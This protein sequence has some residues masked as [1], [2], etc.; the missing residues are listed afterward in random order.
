[1]AGLLPW[2][3]LVLLDVKHMDDSAHRAAT[4]VSNRL[5]LANARRLA[6][7]GVPLIVRTPVVPGVNDTPEAIR[8]VAEFIRGFPNLRYY[9]L[10]P[11]HRMAGGKY[12]SLGL[13]YAAA[14]LLPPSAERLQALAE[15]A[16]AAGLVDVRV[17]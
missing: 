13:D 2:L 12:R 15:A 7:S 10:M 8:A 5:I 14:G 9:E 11:F 6:Q 16:R 3:D 1:M 17:A 4:G